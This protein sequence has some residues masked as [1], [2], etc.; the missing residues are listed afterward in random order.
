VDFVAEVQHT[1]NVRIEAET[2]DDVRKW[3]NEVEDQPASTKLMEPAV[4]EVE[5]PGRENRG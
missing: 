3:L 4:L 2:V 1:R 5:I